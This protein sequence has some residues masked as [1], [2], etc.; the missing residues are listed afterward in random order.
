[1][2]MS[3]ASPSPDQ[4][5]QM[6]KVRCPLCGSQQY[7]LRFR[8]K[9]QLLYFPDTF[10]LVE[11]VD[12]QLLYLSPQPVDMTP[13]YDGSYLFFEEATKQ[14]TWQPL[15]QVL[16]AKFAAANTPQGNPPAEAYGPAN[17]YLALL[18]QSGVPGA[19]RLLD[20]GC[21]IGD[22]LFALRHSGWAIYGYDATT[23]VVQRANV[24]LAELN[25]PVVSSGNF[26]GLYPDAYFNVVTLW[27][28][29]E[30]LPNPLDT[31]REI[32]RI[33]QPGGICIVQTPRIDSAEARLFGRFWGGL[34]SPRH[35]CVFS[36]NTLSKLLAQAG[37]VDI[38]QMRDSSC[39]VFFVSMMFWLN[40]VAPKL[41]TRF[42]R[43]CQ[44][45]LPNRLFHYAFL[46]I[47]ALRLGGQITMLVHKPN[48]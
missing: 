47:D 27:H 32:Q 2:L 9:D 25:R 4:T 17:P 20:F 30:H 36:A 40:A 18:K 34:D 8:T 19:G 42:Y 6:Q 24:R 44:R 43:F 26:K 16:R 15:M 21:G 1:M 22:F 7:R 23:T 48:A 33:L 45:P 11:C 28:V 14:T 10:S 13:F 46:I 41:G 12:C 3:S 29:I 37:F 35:L 5:R 38:R 31:M 39:G